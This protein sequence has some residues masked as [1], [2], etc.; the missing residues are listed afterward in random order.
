MRENRTYMPTFNWRHDGPVWKFDGGVGRAYGK[1]AIRSMDKGMF[2]TVIGRRSN[3]TVNFDQIIDTRPGV[4]TVL[5]GTTRAPVDPYRIDTYSFISAAENPQQASDINFSSFLNARRDFHASVPLTLRAGLDFRQSTRDSNAGTNTWTYR[6]SA[7][8]GSA[9]GLVDPGHGIGS[10][11][12]GHPGNGLAGSTSH[13]R[14]RIGQ[15]PLQCGPSLGD[16]GFRQGRRGFGSQ[17]SI[18]ILEKDE[19]RRHD[20]LGVGRDP[21]RSAGAEDLAISVQDYGAGISEED[22]P[23]VFEKFYRGEQVRDGSVHGMGLG[24]PIVKGLVEAHGG[25][26]WVQD[27]AGPGA[28]VS[29]TLPIVEEHTT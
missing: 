11:T 2:L 12:Q 27:R 29:F 7:V 20:P 21:N 23:H 14:I 16:P 18:G 4:I 8:P 5:D 15:Q 28:T 3:V 9:A 26:I 24:L 17:A 13:E 25:R 22:K 19:Q 1:N 6:G 10:D